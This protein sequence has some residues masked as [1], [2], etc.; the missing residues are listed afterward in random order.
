M[1]QK[2]KTAVFASPLSLLLAM[3]LSIA[4]FLGTHRPESVSPDV[5]HRHLFLAGAIF[6]FLSLVFSRFAVGVREEL[7]RER[8]RLEQGYSRLLLRVFVVY[9]E[10]I[11]TVVGVSLSL[12][13]LAGLVF[14]AERFGD[15]IIIV[16]L[17]LGLG[18]SA[19]AFLPAYLFASFVDM[20]RYPQEP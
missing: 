6:I 10:L 13:W 8:E 12:G 18:L 1:L 17:L 2:V 19:V 20:I 15:Q 9:K 4:F 3:F 7:A 5:L 16:P 14:I 11:K